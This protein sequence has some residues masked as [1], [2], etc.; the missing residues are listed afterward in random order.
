MH[1]QNTFG[2]SILRIVRDNPK[3]WTVHFGGRRGKSLR[4]SY[5][6]L[7]T[8]GR[9]G[10]SMVCASALHPSLPVASSFLLFATATFFFSLF[11]VRMGKFL[12]S[13]FIFLTAQLIRFFGR[14]L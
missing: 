6:A 1:L 14:C 4:R 7:E 9:D 8:A 3:E 13:A 11:F 12:S 2:F 5:L 10:K